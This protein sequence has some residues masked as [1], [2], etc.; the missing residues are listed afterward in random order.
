MSTLSETEGHALSGAEGLGEQASPPTRTHTREEEHEHLLLDPRSQEEMNRMVLDSLDRTGTSYWIVIALL[1]IVALGGFLGGWFYQIWFGM[2]VAGIRRP[3]FWG[4]YIV[5]FVFWIGIS[6]SGTFVSAILRVFKA[7][8]RRPITR[9]AEMMTAVS[10][11]I[12]VAFL[13]IHVGRTWR[14]YWIA[15]YPNQRGLWPN[16]HSP[17]LWDEMAI[18]SYLVG[19]TLYL[20]LPLIPDLA[21]AR[22]HTA[23]WRY[24]LYRILSLGWR[25]TEKQWHNLQ[26]AI[27]IF[28]FVIIPVMFSVHTIVSWDFA[29]TKVIGWHSS[30]F[31]PYFIAGAVYSGIAAVINILFLVRYNMKLSYFV[32]KE[33][34]ES[35]AKLLLVFSFVWTY[36][37]FSDFIVEWYGGDAI[38]HTLIS[39]QTLGP[40]APFWFIMLA[41]NI[42]IPWLTLWNKRLRNNPVALFLIAL[43]INVGMYMERYI[44]V[45]GFLRRNRVPFNWGTYAP[46]I[47]ELLISIG[48]G[49]AFLLL[50]ALFTRLFPAIPIWEVKDGQVAHGRRRIGKAVVTTVAEL[51]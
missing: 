2:G 44:I 3:N 15:P 10:L 40:M 8:Y 24:K 26:T 5:N 32:R 16:F 36:F 17:F 13:G 29:M 12:A 20:Y 14:G 42:V 43:T 9:A 49:A 39:I 38:G 19:S 34:F 27:K 25:G 11:L 21:M 37:F 6:H 47:V 31:G 4:V 33:H 35:L 46:S 22:D 28:A 18:I 48:S 30:L 1:A 51:E 50:Y 23:G 45:T 41:C 7:E